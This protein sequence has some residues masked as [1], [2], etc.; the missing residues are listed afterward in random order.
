[1]RH[2]V[3][4]TSRLTRLVGNFFA[5]TDTYTW[6]GVWYHWCRY[7]LASTS[8]TLASQ[9]L[10][11]GKDKTVEEEGAGRAQVEEDGRPLALHLALHFATHSWSSS[12]S[13]LLEEDEVAPIAA[14]NASR[15]DSNSS[16]EY[17]A[18]PRRRCTL[19]ELMGWTVA[20]S[21][22][23]SIYSPSL[24]FNSARARSHSGLGGWFSSIA[25]EEEEVV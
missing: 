8:A 14:L 4:D 15:A 11:G 7:L 19:G 12:S 18:I 25:C 23:A 24:I 6:V 5:N 2:V 13:F 21:S 3:L 20:Q 16:R 1:M 9:G 10:N 22:R 17:R